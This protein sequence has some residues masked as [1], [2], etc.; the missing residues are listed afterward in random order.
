MIAVSNTSP[1]ASLHLRLEFQTQGQGI[2]R[3]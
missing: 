1:L 2:L 3:V